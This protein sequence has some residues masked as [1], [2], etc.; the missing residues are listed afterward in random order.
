MRARK[1]IADESGCLPNGS[2]AGGSSGEGGGSGSAAG[3]LGCCK[4]LLSSLILF[5]GV[6]VLATGSHHLTGDPEDPYDAVFSND[7]LTG[8]PDPPV[9]VRGMIGAADGWSANDMLCMTKSQQTTERGA[10]LGCVLGVWVWETT[11]PRPPPFPP[12]SSTTR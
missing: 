5:T 11:N 6:A 1:V 7:L 9:S 12:S 10:T 2:M 4:F 8:T 3:N